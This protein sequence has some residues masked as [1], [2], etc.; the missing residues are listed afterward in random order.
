MVNHAYLLIG[1]PSS[2]LKSISY[3]NKFAYE[4]AR[5]AHHPI[6][7]TPRVQMR[8]D[9]PREWRSVERVQVDRGEKAR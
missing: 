5:R 3:F 6:M 7:C 4:C 8:V 1:P 9:T 2:S